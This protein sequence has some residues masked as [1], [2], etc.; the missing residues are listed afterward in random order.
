MSKL[1]RAKDNP[2][3][4]WAY[5][6]P[7]ESFW[8]SGRVFFPRKNKRQA[9]ETQQFSSPHQ[10]KAIPRSPNSFADARPFGLR[11]ERQKQRPGCDADPQSGGKREQRRFKRNRVLRLD[12][13][14]PQAKA[15]P[16]GGPKSP[17]KRFPPYEPTFSNN[18][19]RCAAPLANPSAPFC[20]RFAAWRAAHP[21][22]EAVWRRRPGA[23]F[24]NARSKT[25]QLLLFFPERN[26]KGSAQANRLEI[27]P[28][29]LS[30]A[31]ERR[32]WP[33]KQKSQAR[34]GPPGNDFVF[35]W[36][37]VREK[38]C[39][40]ALISKSATKS[41][42]SIQPQPPCCG[43]SQAAN[44]DASNV[45]L[46]AF[47]LMKYGGEGA[48]T[49]EGVNAS[50]PLSFFL[51]GR[52]SARIARQ[53]ASPQLEPTPI[54]TAKGTFSLAAPSMISGTFCL[55]IGSSSSG[56]SKISSS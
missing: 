48:P 12:R 52:G 27:R 39:Q 38:S 44:P 15:A 31:G 33:P 20:R 7:S 18:P 34:M 5:P 22:D 42:R 9:G 40:E 46:R 16:I 51:G 54:S 14:R 53:C 1:G 29:R 6:P 32:A 37:G 55:M 45:A 28:G 17:T 30:N 21:S 41:R 47:R 3:A 10:N 13:L 49:A 23:R 8:V 26:A 36:G 19:P 50:S 2:G 24:R 43:G 35:F 4:S 56:A 11:A 25:V